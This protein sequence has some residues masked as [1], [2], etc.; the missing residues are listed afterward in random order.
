M[1]SGFCNECSNDT[2][3]TLEYMF[4]IKIT[5][6]TGTLWIHVLGLQGE[7]IMGVTA[8]VLREIKASDEDEFNTYLKLA[9]LKVS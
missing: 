5:D 8:D 6:G 2:G 3:K 4:D 1:T 7:A 9:R